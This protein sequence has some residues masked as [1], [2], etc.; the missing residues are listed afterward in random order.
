MRLIKI[1]KNTLLV[2]MACLALTTCATKK[3]VSNV[4]GP[5]QGDGLHRKDTGEFLDGGGS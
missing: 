1:L 3:E 2:L 4:Q 5:M